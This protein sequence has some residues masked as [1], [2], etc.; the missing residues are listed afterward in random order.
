MDE[1]EKIARALAALAEEHSAFAHSAE[2]RLQKIQTQAAKAA[3]RGLNFIVLR[4]ALCGDTSACDLS[5]ASGRVFVAGS[6]PWDAAELATFLENRG[7]TIQSAPTYD[8]DV[9]LGSHDWSHGKLAPVLELAREK[10]VA[11]YSQELFVLG[12]AKQVDPYDLVDQ[13]LIDQVGYSHPAIQHLL[14]EGAV[15][16]DWP[17][18]DEGEVDSDDEDASDFQEYS[19]YDWASESML[20]KLGYTARQFALT[21][22]DRREILSRAFIG[23]LPKRDEGERE[24]WGGPS[25][26][27]RLLAI[28]SFIAWLVRFQGGD[29]PEAAEKWE[30]DLAWLRERFY[31]DPMGFQWPEVGSSPRSGAAR[32]RTRN[33]NFMAPL[34]PSATLAAVIGQGPMP[35]TEVVSRL[36]GYIKEHRLQDNVNKRMVNT[37]ER[38][39]ALFGKR[40]VSMF[41]MAGLL[42]KH[43]RP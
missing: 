1:A 7:F 33:E 17:D 40:Q 2:A 13:A 16:P 29:K 3:Y 30:S 4:D 41:E 6:G 21:E 31:R 28:S 20:H 37:D 12:I 38:L 18:V 25:S 9:V 32:R 23:P 34:H 14:V 43:L 36:W 39:A 10:K 22:D 27:R 35:R 8:A 24:R 15:W 5:W 11:V 42:G 19:T 26:A